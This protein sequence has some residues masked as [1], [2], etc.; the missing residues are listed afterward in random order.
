MV[1]RSLAWQNQQKCTIAFASFSKSK[2]NRN[3][4]CHNQAYMGHMKQRLQWDTTPKHTLGTA[5]ANLRCR[6]VK[7]QIDCLD[8]LA[9]LFLY[10]DFL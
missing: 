8:R 3:P 5:L 9:L 1:S 4:L 7:A 2:S 10:F 6:M